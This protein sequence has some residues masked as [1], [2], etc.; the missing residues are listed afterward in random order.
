MINTVSHKMYL[1][2]WFVS[3]IFVRLIVCLFA[4]LVLYFSN[5]YFI[6][7]YYICIIFTLVYFVLSRINRFPLWVITFVL[8]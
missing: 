8:K 5:Y 7:F 4:I 3:S 2:F 6:L 1:V